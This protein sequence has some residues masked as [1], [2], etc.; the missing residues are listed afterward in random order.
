MGTDRLD[1]RRC[2]EECRTKSSR[3]FN[4]IIESWMEPGETLEE[5]L[6]I[7]DEWAGA[8]VSYLKTMI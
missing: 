2:F 1:G 8:G 6:R 4:I 5:T 7:E 3:S